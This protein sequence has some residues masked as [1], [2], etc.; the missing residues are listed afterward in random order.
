MGKGSGSVIVNPTPGHGNEG[1]RLCAL[2]DILL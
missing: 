2:L 1:K